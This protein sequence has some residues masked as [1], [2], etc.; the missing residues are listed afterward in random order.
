MEESVVCPSETMAARAVM[1]S[2]RCAAVL[3]LIAGLL[4]GANAA[5]RMP[6]PEVET[7]RAAV[8][9]EVISQADT[10]NLVRAA[11]QPSEAWNNTAIVLEQYVVSG[12][13]GRYAGEYVKVNGASCNGHPFFST[14]PIVDSATYVMWNNGLGQ[15]P[16]QS[17]WMI[18]SY[19]NFVEG[20]SCAYLSGFAQSQPAGAC[21]DSPAGQLCA[22][23][24]QEGV[25]GEWVTQPDFIVAP[26]PAPPTD[27]G[28]FHP[29][30]E[31]HDLVLSA[32]TSYMYFDDG[33]TD[34]GTTSEKYTWEHTTGNYAVESLMNR[35]P[36]VES[37]EESSW[38]K[39]MYLPSVGRTF[40]ISGTERT[41][42]AG[43]PPDRDILQCTSYDGECVLDCW[44]FAAP[45][46]SLGIGLEIEEGECTVGAFYPL[47]GP[48]VRLGTSVLQTFTVDPNEV[49]EFTRP[50]GGRAW[51][52]IV[53]EGCLD[54]D[55]TCIPVSLERNAAVDFGMG[56]TNIESVRA[57]YSNWDQASRPP[58]YWDIPALCFG[59]FDESTK[60]WRHSSKPSRR[61]ATNPA[62]QPQ[63]E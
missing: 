3:L 18:N 17:R 34:V 15:P 35:N 22:G 19:A 8:G 31:E 50:L 44:D 24:W 40:L 4:S 29:Q 9:A 60:Q 54:D 13:T 28:C 11:P 55:T 30:P 48:T 33:T 43:N 39:V 14:G 6:T 62:H 2:N 23:N 5:P 61:N 7:G 46:L 38:G 20:G 25:G 41:A 16:G 26:P 56:F 51:P 49:G 45:G 36:V 12:G 52:H 58:A 32:E 27:W 42:E 47:Q 57:T 59:D 10:S 63:N 37:P 1:L 53:V 21:E